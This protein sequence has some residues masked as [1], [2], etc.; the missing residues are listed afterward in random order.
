MLCDI[1]SSILQFRTSSLTFS[2]ISPN[3]LIGMVRKHLLYNIISK[4]AWKC[5]FNNLLNCVNYI[6]WTVRWKFY[7]ISNII[8]EKVKIWFKIYVE[9]FHKDKYCI[10]SWYSS[11][12]KQQLV[13][14]SMI[15]FLKTTWNTYILFNLLWYIVGHRV[16]GYIS[17]KIWSRKDN[18]KNACII[19][20][21]V[22]YSIG[23]DN[24]SL[25]S[26]I[27]IISH[28]TYKY[29]SVI[30]IIYLGNV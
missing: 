19:F 3:Y 1:S 22:H 15:V 2:S 8:Y 30:L 17:L 10:R 29:L 11:F 28:F 9:Q 26:L 21:S 5:I 18:S 25:L 27:K 7:N 23:L 16:I 14:L 13:F 24:A 20:F 12:I 6:K 4:N